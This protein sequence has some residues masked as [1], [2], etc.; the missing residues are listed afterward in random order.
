MPWLWA[1]EASAHSPAT[2]QPGPTRLCTPP[3]FSCGLPPNFRASA[4]ANVAV[5]KQLMSDLKPFPKSTKQ[6][7]I[8]EPLFVKAVLTSMFSLLRS[9]QFLSVSHCIY[10]MSPH[11]ASDNSIST[12]LSEEN[13]VFN[14]AGRGFSQRVVSSLVLG[15][16][17]VQEC[18]SK[19]CHFCSS[20]TTRED[21]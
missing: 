15:Y 1:P 13:K 8:L 6:L 10:L 7:V 17:L 14:R 19:T 9:W 5:P 20:F 16:F 12:L 18:P 3:P 2:P 21:A 11:W 4:D